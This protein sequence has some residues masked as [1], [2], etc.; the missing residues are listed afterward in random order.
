MKKAVLAALAAA[1]LAGLAGAVPSATG[2]S[3][4]ERYLVVLAGTQG[5]EGF[6]STGSHAAVV[7]AVNA[8]GGTI[9]N[10]LS[11]QVGVLVAESSVATFVQVLS[12]SALVQTVGKD[13]PFKGLP[14]AG[15]EQT[16]DP[17]E[18]LQW[19]MALI[20]APQAHNFQAGSRPVDVGVLDSG[21]DGHHPDFVVDGT[22]VERRLRPRPQ[23]GHLPA[24]R[25][26]RR[27]SRPVRRQPVPR[28]ARGGHDR[29]AGER[30]S[31]S[32]AWR[33]T[34]P[35]CRSRPA[36]RAATATSAASSTGIT[37]AGDVKLDVDQHE[38]LRRRRRLPGVDRVQVQL[39]P[40][41]AG[42]P[43]GGRAGA[44]VCASA[45]RRRLVAALGNSDEDLG[46]PSARGRHGVRRRPGRDAG[47]DRRHGARAAEREGGLLELR[48]GATTSP[49]PA[50]TARPATADDDPLDAAGRRVRLHPG[51]VDGLA[52]CRRRRGADREP[53]R[54]AR[55]E[56]R[57]RAGAGQGRVDPAAPA[58]D[59]G[60]PATTSASATA[61][62]TRSARSSETL[63]A[64]RLLGAV[65]RRVHGVGNAPG[66]GN[67]VGPY[68]PLRLYRSVLDQRGA[69]RARLSR[70]RGIEVEHVDV[71]PVG[72]KRGP[73]ATSAARS[74][75]RCWST[76]ASAS[77]P[78]RP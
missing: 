28:H 22:A 78:T 4:T 30:R 31:A 53:V 13:K 41:P 5:D 36:T 29:R 16:A 59:I 72:P 21:I 45:R 19:D 68:P 25:A 34:S 38:L 54:Q 49:L 64:L 15:P 20:R 14:D 27:Q 71:D 24:E 32:S 67:L 8:A 73:S 18:P 46:N 62:S 77:S 74:T 43:P 50:A 35:S 44:Q 60:L 10:D 37:Y 61:G 76:R 23:L 52:A 57:R 11:R 39:R 12:S 42:V 70:T 56:R 66:Q 63:G 58:T 7:A 2:A 47:R 17:L 26:G 75:C 40:T 65:L 51:H 48:Q 6:T 9:A 3:A 33:R 55:Q 69:R 1:V